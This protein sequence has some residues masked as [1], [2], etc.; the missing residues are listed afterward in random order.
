MWGLPSTNPCWHGYYP[1][2]PSPPQF[3][4]QNKE[5]KKWFICIFCV[6]CKIINL[7]YFFHN[8]YEHLHYLKI[9]LTCIYL[10]ILDWTIYFLLFLK[11]LLLGYYK[12]VNCY[13][14]VTFHYWNHNSAFKWLIIKVICNFKQQALQNTKTFVES[15]WR[16]CILFYLF[17]F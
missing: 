3:H 1:V 7:W 17:F 14:R 5:T 11:F 9:L 12:R 2:F 15:R 4:C 6:L 10:P 13:F 8:A 16:I